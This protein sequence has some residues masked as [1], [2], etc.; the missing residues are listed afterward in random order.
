MRHI[1][2]LRIYSDSYGCS[3]FEVKNI[4]LESKDYAPPAPPLFTS[5]LESATNCVFLELPVGW[6]GDWHPTPVRQWLVLMTGECEFE[7]GNGEKIIHKAG[8]VVLLD[9]TTG[10]GHR[11]KVL[12]NVSVR[13]AAIHLKFDYIE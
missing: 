5:A 8:D 12:G 13:I 10:K 9:D 1:N 3:H 4:E 6:Y 2:Y 7:A 11:T